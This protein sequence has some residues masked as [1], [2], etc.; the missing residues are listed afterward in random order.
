M[1]TLEAIST[2]RSVRE[3]SDQ[4]V[5][6]ETIDKILHAAMQAPSAHNEQPWHFIVINDRT[7][8]DQIPT[9]HP[10]SQM[11]LKASVAIVP[12]F[13]STLK[14][15]EDFLA[16]DLAASVQNILLAVRALDLGAVWVGVYPNETITEKV[17]NL[18]NLP[19]QITPFNIIPIGYTDV[20]QDFIDRYKKNRV[21]YN[22]W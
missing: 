9:I 15:A 3:F 5:S 22:Q 12:C 6:E 17:K 4:P 13:D 16:Q 11:C 19:E 7:I 1:D 14:K 21:H 20:K 8:L 10:Y 2:R 18:L